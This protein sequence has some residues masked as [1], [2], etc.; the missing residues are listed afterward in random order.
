MKRVEVRTVFAAQVMARETNGGCVVH[1]T[2][3]GILS[4]GC[5]TIHERVPENGQ[6]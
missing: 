5:N 2:G 6:K 3:A 1:D 4:I